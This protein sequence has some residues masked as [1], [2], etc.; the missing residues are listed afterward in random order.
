ML[1]ARIDSDAV[2]EKAVKVEDQTGDLI[3]EGYASTWDEDRQGEAFV[4]G[5]F[6]ETIKAFLDG[7]APLLYQHKDGAQLGTVEFLEERAKGLWMRARMPEP[8]ESSPLRHQWELAKRGMLRGASV[9]GLM[10]KVG[11][12]LMMK[13]LYEVSLTPAPVNAGGLV[14]VTQKALSD[15]DDSQPEPD[16]A[17]AVR[18]WLEERFDEAN[19]AFDEAEQR[20]RDLET[21]IPEPSADADSED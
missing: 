20:I 3:L 12:K 7:S 16:D 21:A 8:P 4:P 19:R 14:A 5:S 11:N 15:E 10:R 9:R 6:R 18:K 13:D 2:L 17:D 1:E